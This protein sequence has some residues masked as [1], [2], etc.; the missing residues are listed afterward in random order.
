MSTA[1]ELSS[2]SA[3]T[4][5]S[6]GTPR[7]STPSAKAEFSDDGAMQTFLTMAL[8]NTG[9]HHEAMQ[10]LLKL[11]AATSN[12]PHVHQYRRAIETY[13]EDLNATV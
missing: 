5:Y 6:A 3:A 8:F 4:G 7:R 2:A 10:I 9:Q 13:A 1:A 12:D 11:L